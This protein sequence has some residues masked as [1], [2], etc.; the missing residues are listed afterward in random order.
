MVERGLGC[1][2]RGIMVSPHKDYTDYKKF[3]EWLRQ[4]PFLGKYEIEGFLVDLD[5]EVRLKPLTFSTLAS[6]LLQANP[7]TTQE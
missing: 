1:G 2:C 6:H 3:L 7:E 4:S 5:D